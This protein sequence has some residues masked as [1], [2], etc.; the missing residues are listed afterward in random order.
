MSVAE[1][2]RVRIVLEKT[3]FGGY[4]YALHD[5]QS[6]I[7]LASGWSAGTKADARDEARQDARR[8]GC[9]VVR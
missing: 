4:E 6:D 9:E 7:V 5:A 2:R 3:D 1:K 8:L